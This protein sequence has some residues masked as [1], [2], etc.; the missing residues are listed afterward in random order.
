MKK[1]YDR[2]GLGPRGLRLSLGAPEADDILKKRRARR[3]DAAG[4]HVVAHAQALE[5]SEILK[6]PRD[7]ELGEALC[8]DLVEIVSVD[9]DPA[10][11]GSID[12]DNDVQQ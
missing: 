8:R 5:Q 6:R 4:N 7:A 11:I 10:A 1:V 12:A 9:R 2:V 3:G